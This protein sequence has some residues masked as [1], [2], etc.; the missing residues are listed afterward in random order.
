MEITLGRPWRHFLLFVLACIVAAPARSSSITIMPTYDTSI[1]NDA[2][3]SAIEGAIQTAINQF[4]HLITNNIT[5]N[6]YFEETTFPSAVGLS[7]DGGIYNV[8]YGALYSQLTA[9]NAN[10]AAIAALAANP[11]ANN[12][13]IAIKAPDG[14]ALGFNTPG[15]C[16][17][18][19]NG[20]AQYDL[21]EL[22]GGSTGTAYDGI[23]AL[24]TSLTN[25]PVSGG[26][27]LV[28]TVEH[29]TDE[30]L[31]LGS[32]LENCNPGQPNQPPACV[33][34]ATLTVDNDTPSHAISIE[35]LFRYS[36]PTG[37]TRTLSAVCSNTP[38]SAYFSYGASTGEIAQFNN[39]CNGEDFGDWLGNSP[40]RVQDA[41]GTPG[42]NPTLAT[43]EIDALTAIGFDANVPEP[44]TWS[45]PAAAI[46][47]LIIRRRL[48]A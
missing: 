48:K 39:A 45:L 26:Y 12:T 2:N 7:D 25:P 17:L 43:P 15:V 46:A 11:L 16:Q 28:S 37:G 13:P 8:N 36:A 9:N 10:T 41:E 20:A 1:Q 30:I 27:G 4:E 33:A 23:I 47:L 3:V 6:I 32:A 44:A 22:C 34:S 42:T 21:N 35:D 14:R 31:G 24:N 29:E 38:T 18:T 19:T 5:V 40:V